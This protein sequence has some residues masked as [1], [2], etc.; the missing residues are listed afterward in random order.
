M[1]RVHL[2]SGGISSVEVRAGTGGRKPSE[3]RT[4]NKPLPRAPL[5]ARCVAD[6]RLVAQAEACLAQHKQPPLH[7]T[8]PV[9]PDAP[10]TKL[11][12]KGKAAAERLV[13]C[14][15]ARVKSAKKA[16]QKV[17]QRAQPPAA[18]RV[19][20]TVTSRAASSTDPYQ[21]VLAHDQQKAARAKA[22][23]ESSETRTAR[24]HGA[25]ALFTNAEPS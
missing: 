20:R 22:E 1:R 15:C 2:H 11:R 8:R 4:E 14:R 9:V 10:G 24:G 21:Q 16:T 6:K 7:S 25:A 18:S 13:R 19:R 12:R 17:G 23:S 5:C 3:W